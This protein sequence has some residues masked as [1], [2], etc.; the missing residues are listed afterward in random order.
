MTKATEHYYITKIASLTSVIA[1]V[2]SLH[3]KING[4]ADNYVCDECSRL[5]GV[6]DDTD[7]VDYPCSTIIALGVPVE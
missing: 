7:Y 4:P 3:A 2:M 6:T 1:D 5:V